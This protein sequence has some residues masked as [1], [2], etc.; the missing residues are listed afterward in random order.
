MFATFTMYLQ[1][2]ESCFPNIA[3][4]Q[5]S[6]SF[7]LNNIT[8]SIHLSSSVSSSLFIL[9]RMMRLWNLSVNRCVNWVALIERRNYF[10]YPLLSD[11][12]SFPWSQHSDY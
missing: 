4:D 1:P 12:F 9:F 7:D 2:M 8:P 5:E 10:T 6:D 3:E 11:I